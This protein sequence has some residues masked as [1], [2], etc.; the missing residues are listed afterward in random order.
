[1]YKLT[2]E[3]D[4]VYTLY[5]GDGDGG[6]NPSKISA[7]AIALIVIASILGVGAIAAAVL[8]ALK[9]KR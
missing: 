3:E 2:V 6:D 7:G 8:V 9:K 1:M 5:L 4:G